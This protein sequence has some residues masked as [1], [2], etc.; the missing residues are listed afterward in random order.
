V[1]R[2]K[3]PRAALVRPFLGGGGG[4]PVA[5]AGRDGA[6]RCEGRETRR[7]AP[8]PRDDVDDRPP[9]EARAP[10]AAPAAD[11]PPL[12][13]DA[14]AALGLAL[15]LRRALQALRLREPTPV[16]ALALPPALSGIDLVA[17][18]PTGTGKTLT[19][20]LALLQ[21]LAERPPAPPARGQRRP[22]R[23]LVVVPTRELAVQVGQALRQ[24]AQHLP[25]P[26][27]QV[28]VFGGVSVNPQMLALRGGAELV[29]GTPGRLL[30]LAERGALDL[31][32]LR[33]WVLDE[34][35]RLLDDSF[36][37]EL[38]RLVALL[39]ARRQGLFFSAT[40]PPGVRTLAQRWLHEPQVL[41][42]EGEAGALTE[43]PTDAPTQEDEERAPSGITQ[44]ALV[45]DTARRTPLLRHLIAQEG[46]S[47]VLVFVATRHAA[48]QVAGKLRRH[49]IAADALHG[50][51]SQGARQRVLDA[52]DQGA[53]CVL[54]ATDL[55]ARGLHLPGL[56]VVL[57][58]DLARSPADHVHRIG[59]TGRAGAAGLAVSF[60]PP[61]AEAHFR[62]IE[63]R[64]GLRVP[65]ETVAGFEPTET[66]PAP[67][68]GGGGVKGRRK[69]K[70]DK[71]REAAAAGT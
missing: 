10:A 37:D 11:L 69:S 32:G 58:W 54:L 67:A 33:Q 53:L 57:N 42:V 48:D 26:P 27:R 5:P 56:P 30:D 38:Q 22:T 4:A 16:Q 7:A 49:G 68:P 44:R 59:R 20:A 17:Q 25:Q 28:V 55:A 60:V 9:R 24:I 47:R 23:A 21:P 34:A 2:G 66:A 13:D 39:P 50:E 46:W 71:L 31:S 61:A 64:Q 35:D 40:F 8:R 15:P 14:F 70:K 63:K 52:F 51:L 41:R 19:Y 1:K 62:L 65:R 36:A 45:V 43:A 3:D 29:I 18:A 6:D 12:R